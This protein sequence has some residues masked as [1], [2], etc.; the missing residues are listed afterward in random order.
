MQLATN[1]L[2]IPHHGLVAPVVN[3]VWLLCQGSCCKLKVRSVRSAC[4][5]LPTIISLNYRRL[6]TLTRIQTTHT[7]IFWKKGTLYSMGKA[8]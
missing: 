8:C 1:T 6:S 5:L 4:S 7:F 3:N 2:L